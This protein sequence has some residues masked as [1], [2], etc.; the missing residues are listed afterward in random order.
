[1]SNEP[2]DHRGITLHQY[3]MT[4]LSA[5]ATPIAPRWPPTE[6]LQRGLGARESRSLVAINHVQ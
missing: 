3:A 1:M 5:F 6:V 4:F 2:E